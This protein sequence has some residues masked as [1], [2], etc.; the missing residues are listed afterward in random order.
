MDK[1]YHEDEKLN[2]FLV[3]Q[4]IVWQFNLSRALWWGRQF[5][6]IIGLT[7]Q[8]MHKVIGN[9]RLK[10]NESE[11]ILLDVEITLNNQLLS[12]V[13]ED[14]QLPLLTPN[15]MLLGQKNALLEQ[16]ATRI[17]DKDLRRR[18]KYLQ[19]CRDNLWRRWKTEYLRTLREGHNLKFKDREPH[20]AVGEVVLIC[21]HEKNR[22][23]WSIGVVERSIKGKDDVVRGARLKTSKSYVERAVQLLYPF[24][25]SCDIE[26][27]V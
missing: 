15:M 14:V 10:L 25:L 26:E 21:G 11:E 7:K 13:K 24:E 27:S 6:R 4:G 8:A 18:A 17:K 16:D 22:G 3:N 23:Q 2:E 5:D 1:R 19:R 9:A 20:I 12:Y